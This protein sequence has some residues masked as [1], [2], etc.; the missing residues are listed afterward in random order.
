MAIKMNHPMLNSNASKYPAWLDNFVD[1]YQ[2]LSTS[3]LKLL[4]NTYHENIVFVDPIHRVEGFDPLYLYFENL[5]QNL[6]SCTFV[7]D[8]V[9]LQDSSAAIYWTMT[10]QHAKLNKGESVTIF[11]NS[12]IKGEDDKVIYH[13]DYLDLGAMLYEQLPLLGRIIRFIKSRLAK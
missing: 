2:R 12:Y 5:Y 13:R 11:G 6:S 3:N 7:I 10:Y 8:N 9:I 1:L 4:K